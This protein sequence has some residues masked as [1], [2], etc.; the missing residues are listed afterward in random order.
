LVE[1][2]VNGEEFD[3]EAFMTASRQRAVAELP[4]AENGYAL[5]RIGDAL[6]TRGLHAAVFDAARLCSRL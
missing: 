2:S 1:R 3:P 4:D 5:F 6:A